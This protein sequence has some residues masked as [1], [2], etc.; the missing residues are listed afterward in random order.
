M[1]TTNR[2]LTL[3][4]LQNNALPW[5]QV[6]PESPY[7]VTEQ[8]ETWMPIGQNDAITWPDLAGL[9]RRKN[10]EA[11]ENYLQMLVNHG[12]TCMRL[13]LEYCHGEH[14]YFEKP[15]GTFAPNM[16]QLWDDMFALCEQYGLRILLTPFDTF[17]MWIRWAK[18]PYNQ[19]NTGPCAA[20]NQWLLCADTR[21]AIKARLAFVTERW[22]GSGALFAW[23]L[24]N[25][26]H[27]AHA[28]NSS[29]VF[30]DFINDISQFLHHKEITLYGRAHL[31]T[32]SVFGPVL[33]E[34]KRIGEIIFRHPHL[35]FANSH[36]YE[37][38][39]INN[40]K[41]TV[42]AAVS[43]GRLVRQ[44]LAEIQDNRPFFDSEHGP[45]HTFKDKKKTLP[46]AFDNEYFRHIQWAHLASGGAG[47]GMRWPNR[48]PHSLTPGMREAQRA[49]HQFLPLLDWKI[50]KRRNWN[51]EVKSSNPQVHVFACGDE[52]QALIW[53]LRNDTK[54]K[55]KVSEIDNQSI[56]T[57]LQLPIQ[58]AGTF[59]VTT[60]DTQS[61]KV[62]EA[63][64][65]VSGDDQ[66]LCV[67]LTLVKN[68]L[69]IA[70][71]R[72]QG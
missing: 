52:H 44:A 13:M 4:R 9:F 20:R 59:Q 6:S 40:P 8:G 68:D 60:W 12:V 69:A 71:R 65:A 42:D 41:N 2:S 37:H 29:E 39:T 23:D 3:S 72:L 7:F 64:Q 38:G 51:E 24:W 14:R 26:I 32:V 53:L 22:G 47:G 27:P 18:H 31:Q 1:T 56:I 54:Q 36:F 34:D 46:E 43:V 25:E 57:K 30:N 5:I 16:V 70:I 21:A 67:P 11:V 62:Q 58:Y 61:G 17:W 48:H 66:I 10:L 50:F 19:Q 63:S 55:D 49:L 45:I 35:Q 28:G 33:D 15:A